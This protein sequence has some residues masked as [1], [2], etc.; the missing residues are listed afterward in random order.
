[1][2]KFAAA[3]LTVINSQKLS[4]PVIGGHCLHLECKVVY[5]QAMDAEGLLPEIKQLKYAQGDYHVFY[6]AEIVAAYITE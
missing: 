5:R 6:G 4:T 1:M 3:G 2:N